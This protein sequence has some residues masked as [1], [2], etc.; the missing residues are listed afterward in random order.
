MSLLFIF[1][2][3]TLLAAIQE[4]LIPTL[5][6]KRP[7]RIIETGKTPKEALTPCWKH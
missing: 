6:R 3:L 7:R 1:P 5:T 2:P 4:S